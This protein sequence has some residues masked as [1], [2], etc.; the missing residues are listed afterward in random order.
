MIPLVWDTLINEL[1]NLTHIS[2][3]LALNIRNSLVESLK[4]RGDCYIWGPEWLMAAALDP[5]F[6][7][8]YWPPGRRRDEIYQAIEEAYGMTNDWN[9]LI[10]V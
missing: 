2:S 6:K 9:D 4:R 3:P 8:L 1:N 7:Q 10:A 5:R